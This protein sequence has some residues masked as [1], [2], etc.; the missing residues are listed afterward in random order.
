MPIKL[1]R[2][3]SV[4]IVVFAIASGATA[5]AE[6]ASESC[7]SSQS[8]LGDRTLLALSPGQRYD[9]IEA[10]LSQER[11]SS[12]V[13]RSRLDLGEL[14]LVVVEWPGNDAALIVT[15]PAGDGVC[16]VTGWGYSFGGLGVQL[17]VADHGTMRH[18]GNDWTLVVL[19]ALATYNNPIDDPS[20]PD[21]PR[22]TVLAIG[23]ARSIVLA[24]TH[25]RPRANPA[26]IRLS[27]W[28][29]RLE[30]RGRR[31]SVRMSR[32]GHVRRFVIDM[33]AERL[34]PLRRRVTPR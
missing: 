11:R 15:R 16:V 9:S 21:E 23:S 4:L 33:A 5:R 19:E 29:W 8:W 31:L 28:S 1:P 34:R 27:S 14:T 12:W 20:D 13:E 30:R 24:D 25:S 18:D 3:I 7:P 17:T 10:M 2:F 6:P 22:R 32:G 26:L